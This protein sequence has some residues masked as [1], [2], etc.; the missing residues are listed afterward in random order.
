MPS[1]RGI[2]HPA[3]KLT[4]EA[5]REIRRAYRPG[6][7]SY[8]D[9]AERY[10]VSLQLVSQIINRQAWAWLEDGPPQPKPSGA[11][12]LFFYGSTQDKA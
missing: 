5:V 9:I 7:I 8:R 1:L 4:P 12:G 11:L 2:E 6:W 10:G 3:H